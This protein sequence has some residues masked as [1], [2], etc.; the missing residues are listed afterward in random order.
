MSRSRQNVPV[1]ILLGMFALVG[2]DAILGSY[3]QRVRGI[4]GPDPSVVEV[5]NSAEVHERVVIRVTTGGYNGCS[6]K[7]DTAVERDQSHVLVRPFDYLTA[8]ED[9]SDC[10]QMVMY[11]EHEVGLEF[12]EPGTIT[13]R[14]EGRDGYG[15]ERVIERQIVIEES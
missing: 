4:L 9:E 8:P 15:G 14:V 3:N 6:R 10:V 1:T 11:F 7:G 5:P 2:C 12:D 13:V